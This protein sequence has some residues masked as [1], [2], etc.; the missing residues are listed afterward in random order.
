MSEYQTH[1]VNVVFD[2]TFDDLINELQ[3]AGFDLQFF[4]PGLKNS[5]GTLIIERTPTH[6]ALDEKEGSKDD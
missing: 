6:K 3:E 2:G 4:P 1:S 5:D